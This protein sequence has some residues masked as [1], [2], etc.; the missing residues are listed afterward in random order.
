[1]RP[2]LCPRSRTISTPP[3][4]AGGGEMV[5]AAFVSPNGRSGRKVLDDSDDGEPRLRAVSLGAISQ[6]MADR[7][8]A[9]ERLGDEAPIHHHRSIRRERRVA[10]PKLRPLRPARRRAG[11]SSRPPRRHSDLHARAG[12]V[13]LD[14]SFRSF[15]G[16]A[17]AVVAPITPRSPPRRASRSAWIARR[18]S[19]SGRARRIVD[20]TRPS[21]TSGEYR[22]QTTP[23]PE[24]RVRWR[25][26]DQLL[27]FHQGRRER[28]D[29]DR[30]LGDDEERPSRPECA[31]RP[32]AGHR[33][34]EAW[35][36]GPERGQDPD[37]HRAEHREAEDA[38]PCRPKGRDRSR[39]APFPSRR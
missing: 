16:I 8:A 4:L 10:G 34:V 9:A 24:T 26:P 13:D 5:H 22:A 39:T 20:A 15:P 30:D 38:A 12:P 36:G 21:R 6:A 17:T 27:A 3:H 25:R 2:A 33:R 32:G 28:R 7:V 31:L 1:M 18:L 14:R 35:A 19:A 11:N 23:P 29:G 37:D